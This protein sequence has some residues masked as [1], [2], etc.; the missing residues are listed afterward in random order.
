MGR[1]RR[2]W[3]LYKL[4]TALAFSGFT[5]AAAFAVGVLP[6]NA[7]LGDIDPLSAVIALLGL[8][9]SLWLS[10]HQPFDLTAEATKLAA[11]VLHDET[12][13]RRQLL[14]GEVRPIDI[15]FALR[16]APR[17]AH[18][19][20]VT[21]TLA[22]V[23][24]YFGCHRP[25]RLVITG[26]AGS[27]KTFLAIDLIVALLAGRAPDA[28]VP[29]RLTAASWNPDQPVEEWLRS[30]LRRTFGLRPALARALVKGHMVLPVVDGIDEMDAVAAPGYASRAG[31]A[32]RAIDAYQLGRA[33]AEIVVTCRTHQYET[34]QEAEAGTRDVA[35][36]QVQPVE[37]DQALTFL[38]GRC[39]SIQRWAKVLDAIDFEPSGPLAQGLATPWRLTLAAI[40][41][42]Q[43][44]ADGTYRHDP[45]ALTELAS[46]EEVGE[47]LLARVIDA[48][49]PCDARYSGRQVHRGL[50]VLARYLDR[51]S[52]EPLPVL[53]RRPLPSTDLVLHE[54]W[55]LAGH[56]VPR[57]VHALLIGAAWL[58]VLLVMGIQPVPVDSG[59]GPA[60]VGSGS[61]SLHPLDL[62]DAGPHQLLYGPGLE[63]GALYLIGVVLMASAWV[64][65]PSPTRSMSRA[66]TTRA[67]RRW[68]VAG[69]IAG[70]L[71]VPAVILPLS[72]IIAGPLG[73]MSLLMG[74][75]MTMPVPGFLFLL[76]GLV[77]AGLMI[78][79]ASSRAVLGFAVGLLLGLLGLAPV[80][81]VLSFVSLVSLASSRPRDL[82]ATLLWIVL[83]NVLI[84]G[85]GGLVLYKLA[86]RF[87]GPGKAGAHDP[88]WAVR[89]DAAAGLLF[90]LLSL[91]ASMFLGVGRTF[92]T[93]GPMIAIVAG[94]IISF[95]AVRYL[96][97]LLCTRRW[98]GNPLPWRMGRFLRWCSQAGLIRVAGT[99]YQF[100]HRELQDY[101]AR[102][103][104]PE[105]AE[106]LENAGSA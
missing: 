85:L 27:G 82:P 94:S 72:L 96:A 28:P 70:A 19:L 60:R 32:L 88:C 42:E 71:L 63:R 73:F 43:R 95:V 104:M 78:A 46:A 18:G 53:G 22:E 93:L 1:K 44:E 67:G 13:A 103:P 10:L 21:G 31:R 100:R 86:I 7:E 56:H 69:L 97:F 3:D 49:T 45:D 76:G 102:H 87:S 11:E 101:L 77:V 92:S 25:S 98:S 50:A 8:A 66:L 89:S 105:P 24:D 17:E 80:S 62:G 75:S 30:H 41:Y 65:W 57:I 14:G 16:R 4:I 5:V 61:G 26:A 23:V 99:A 29:I 2:P 36:V 68:L 6:G 38:E 52:A 47:H 74:L 12:I 15:T 90:A 84:L 9:A 37:P 33:H 64:H 34:L 35:W 91:F 55:P 58:L 79:F 20:P 106:R 51:N 39:T 54:L 40:V 59:S 81:H 48:A 83:W